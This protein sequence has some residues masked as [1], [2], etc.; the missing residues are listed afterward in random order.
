MRTAKREIGEKTDE[1]ASLR[2]DETMRETLGS[3]PVRACGDTTVLPSVSPLTEVPAEEDVGAIP[4]QA[5][6]PEANI[7][8]QSPL[9]SPIQSVLAV[10]QQQLERA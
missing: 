8:T 2:V 6:E 5:K 9:Y 3:A 7:P 10:S 1:G 4:T